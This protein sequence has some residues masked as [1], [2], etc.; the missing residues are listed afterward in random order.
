MNGQIFSFHLIRFSTNQNLSRTT[1]L[2]VDEN[3]L[4]RE[5]NSIRFFN[6]F[7]LLVLTLKFSKV[8]SLETLNFLNGALITPL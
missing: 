4:S 7:L 8:S 3:I 2:K 5:M 1:N 6:P